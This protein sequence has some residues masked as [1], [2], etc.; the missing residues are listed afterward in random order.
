MRTE[1]LSVVSHLTLS[2]LSF[3]ENNITTVLE[4]SEPLQ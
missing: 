4:S 2:K 3:L 1:Q